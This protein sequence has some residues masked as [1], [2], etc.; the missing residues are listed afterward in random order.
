MQN[1]VYELVSDINVR[2]GVLEERL[3][4]LEEGLS[5]VQDSF[6]ALPNMLKL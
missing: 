2:Q 1:N 5:Q 4:R 6:E 3:A